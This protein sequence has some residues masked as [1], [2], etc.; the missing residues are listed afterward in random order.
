MLGILKKLQVL[1]ISPKDR[2]EDTESTS[3]ACATHPDTLAKVAAR[4]VKT[5]Q[6]I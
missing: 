3:D 5:V 1:L 4:L 6:K 2:I